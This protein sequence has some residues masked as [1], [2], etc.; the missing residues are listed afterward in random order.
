MPDPTELVAR[1]ADYRERAV[2]MKA[3]LLEGEAAVTP[4]IGALS[5]PLENVRWAAARLLG[6]LGD[7]RA[8]PALRALPAEGAPG[9]AAREAITALEKQAP[10][11]VAALVEALAAE[12]D[13]ETRGEGTKWILRLSLPEARSHKVR[14]DFGG[15]D[16]DGEPLVALYAACGEADPAQ[17]ESVLRANTRLRFAALAITDIGGQPHYVVVATHRLRGLGAETLERTV[18]EIAVTADALEKRLSDLDRF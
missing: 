15:R 2:A 6:E 13:V 12:P 14:L 5:H 10:T 8:L 16:E 3:L 7:P 17:Y 4:L 18:H 1:L 11:T 9:E